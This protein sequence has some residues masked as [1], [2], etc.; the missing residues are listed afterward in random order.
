MQKKESPARPARN[1]AWGWR[2]T[3]VGLGSFIGLLIY[4]LSEERG[5]SIL[6]SA[7]MNLL[8]HKG[9]NSTGL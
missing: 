7:G 6:V 2:N 5:Y 4:G 8:K 1:R 3:P 9:I